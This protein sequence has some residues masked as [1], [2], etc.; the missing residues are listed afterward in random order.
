M[1]PS[2]LSVSDA[3]RQRLLTFCQ[4][5]KVL[6]VRYLSAG[7]AGTDIATRD[8]APVTRTHIPRVVTSQIHID[9]A[10]LVDFARELRELLGAQISDVFHKVLIHNDSGGDSEIDLSELVRRVITGDGLYLSELSRNWNSPVDR[11]AFFAIYLARPFRKAVADEV[12]ATWELGYC[13]TCGL[14]PRM[15]HIDSKTGIRRLW[16]AGCETVWPFARLVCPFC[17]ET[18]QK[19]LG[20]LKIASNDQYRL[21]TCDTCRRYLKTKIDDSSLNGS[22]IDF[23]TEYLLTTSLDLTA[24]FEN[25]IQDFIGF[26][27]FD[28]QDNA[29]AQRYLAKAKNNVFS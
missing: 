1:I 25:Y 6:H 26:A 17:L 4:Q 15:A 16:C 29:A 8:T 27:A 20:Y 2:D 11:V 14:W 28:L 19:K 10:L 24:S 9:Q 12:P 5:Y 22:E 21:Y 3:D 23:E 13:P 18:E 7:V